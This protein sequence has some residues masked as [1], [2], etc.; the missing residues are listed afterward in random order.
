MAKTKILATL[1]P[2]S[3]S[4][5]NMLENMIN[6]GLDGFRINMSHVKDY[7]L[8]AKLISDIRVKAP[9]IFIAADLE[10]PKIRLGTIEKPI[11]IEKGQ[12][13]KIAPQSE[14]ASDCVPIQVEHVY[15]HVIPGNTL[16]INDGAVGLQVTDIKDKIIYT[17]VL[18][19]MQ[20]ESRKGVNIPNAYV[21]MKFLS[22]KDKFNLDFLVKNEIDYVSASF[23]QRADDLKEL[24]SNMGNSNTKIIAKIENHEG[25]KNFDSILDCTDAVMVARGDLGMEIEPIYV[26]ENQ[27]M[28]INKCNRSGKMV[29]TATQMLESM[30]TCLEPKRAEISDIFNAVLDG[31]DVVMLSGET[32]MGQY[33][34]ESIDVMN[35]TLER[36]E[37]Y[38]KSTGKSKEIADKIIPYLGNGYEDIISGAINAAINTNGIGAIITLTLSGYTTQRIARF[39]SDIPIIALT[40][41]PM[42]ARQLNAV[43]GVNAYNIELD[44]SNIISESLKYISSNNIVPKGT[45]VIVA[46]GS[47]IGTTDMMQIA[48]LE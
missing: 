4:S 39:R 3:W 30:M 35:K 34:I 48:V 46:S 5:W 33:P 26:P 10:G 16:L 24:R 6:V 43:W 9:N 17:K 47:K 23:T 18:Y 7:N 27:K 44:R 41:N 28:M 38:F 19:G 1:G 42:I 21:P 12:I 40:P 13:I 37:L 14:C 11:A 29:I 32:S 8:I 36:A 20:L 45:Q 15:K 31:T 22:Q 2:S 25:L